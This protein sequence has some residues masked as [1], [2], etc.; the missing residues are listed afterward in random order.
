[1]KILNF[2]RT[3]VGGF[4]AIALMTLALGSLA[5]AQNEPAGGHPIKVMKARYVSD[6]DRG[7]SSARG[8]CTVWIK[9]KA[10]VSVDGIVVEVEIYNDSRRKIETVKREV[11]LLT[12][13]EKKVLTFKWDIPGESEI[14]RPKIFLSYR[15]RGTQVTRFHS[16]PPTWQ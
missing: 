16:E 10:D 12:S 14:R 13:G 11:E 5:A 6:R 3:W 2:K 7:G 15:T 1:M 4:L 8:N 9:N